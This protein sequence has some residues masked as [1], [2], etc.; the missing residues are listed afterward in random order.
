LGTVASAQC[1]GGEGV[2]EKRKSSAKPKG[3]L[4]RGKGGQGNT[5]QLKKVLLG[6]SARRGKQIREKGGLSQTSRNEKKKRQSKSW[7]RFWTG[8]CLGRG[9]GDRSRK[10]NSDGSSGRDLS[11]KKKH[12]SGG[13]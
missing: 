3:G 8:Q 4:S 9:L 6:L 2:S 13:T 1:T 10:E 5:G 12:E 11:K 7:G